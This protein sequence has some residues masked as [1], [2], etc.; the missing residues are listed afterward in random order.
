MSKSLKNHLI[1]WVLP[2]VF[3]IVCMCIYFLDLFGWSN[4]IAPD[5]NREFGLIENV[6]LLI[7]IGIAILA[8]STFTKSTVKLERLFYFGVF[9]FSMVIF[10]EEIDYGIHYYELL[11]SNTIAENSTGV[12]EDGVRNIHNQGDLRQYIMLFVYISFILVLGVMY[13]IKGK[14]DFKNAFLD[15][16]VP[17]SGYFI[18]SLI[19]MMALNELAGFLDQNVKDASI[20]S[21]NGNT[22]EFEETYIYYIALLYIRDLRMKPFPLAS[23]A[24]SQ[25]YSSDE[26]TLRV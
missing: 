19:A 5:L 26:M 4:Q 18:Y 2:S 11:K 23:T 8:F 3:L 14:Y 10:F 15:W 9:L 12:F 7:I 1:Y 24:E 21:L 6:Q 20:D 17:T 25:G 16:I 13:L 22:L